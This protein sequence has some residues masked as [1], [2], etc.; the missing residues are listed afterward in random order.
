LLALF[1]ND[2][3]DAPVTTPAPPET[4]NNT[5]QNEKTLAPPECNN[6][7]VDEHTSA[8]ETNHTIEKEQ[9]TACET[10]HTTSHEAMGNQ[11]VVVAAPAQKIVGNPNQQ[12]EVKK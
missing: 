12:P 9:P 10:N 6:T 11:E 1:L 5:T 4:T 7:T 3:H 8:F 2:Q